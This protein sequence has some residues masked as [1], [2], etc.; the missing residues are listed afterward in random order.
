MTQALRDPRSSRRYV[1]AASAFIARAPQFVPCELCD[2]DVDTTLSRRSKLGP[3]IEHKLPI[4]KILANADTQAQALA[5]ACDESLWGIA[6]LACQSRQGAGVTNGR[7]EP[8]G[9][10]SRDW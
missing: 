1:A 2:Q 8:A 7:A 6:H 9:T 4:R 5:S 10:P 3:T